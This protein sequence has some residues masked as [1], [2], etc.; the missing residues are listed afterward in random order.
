MV[1]STTFISIANWY[2]K[3]LTRFHWPIIHRYHLRQDPLQA[4]GCHRFAIG[5]YLSCEPHQERFSMHT[6]GHSTYFNDYEKALKNT[7]L[8]K[9]AIES[10]D[11][12]F[13]ASHLRVV[14]K[15]LCI[16]LV[17]LWTMPL[18]MAKQ[19][20]KTK[21]ILKQQ[22]NYREEDKIINKPLSCTELKCNEYQTDKDG[23]IDLSRSK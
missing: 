21:Y 23:A 19:N 16:V 11:N 10:P 4:E 9:S 12:K 3:I 2:N 1:V 6:A 18:F 15:V 13:V 17:L 20:I 5:W 22:L 8:N 7:L 14:Q